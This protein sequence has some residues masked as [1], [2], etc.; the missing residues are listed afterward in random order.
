M[1]YDEDNTDLD[2][3]TLDAGIDCTPTAKNPDCLGC[4]SASLHQEI[5]ESVDVLSDKIA[6]FEELLAQTFQVGE[7]PQARLLELGRIMGMAEAGIESLKQAA[8][9]W[10]DCLDGAKAAREKKDS[11]LN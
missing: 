5:Y 7:L 3:D 11:K 2:H 1:I 8:N 6:A 9:Y 10:D 4:M